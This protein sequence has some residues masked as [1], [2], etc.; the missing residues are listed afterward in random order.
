[1]NDPAVLYLW[2]ATSCI[3]LFCAV[4]TA[5]TFTCLLAGGGKGKVTRRKEEVADWV[6]PMRPWAGF[7]ARSTNSGGVGCRDLYLRLFLLFVAP[8]TQI[9]RAIATLTMN[10]ENF[11]AL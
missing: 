3:A 6:E 1:M 2:M 8:L 7:A 11:Y 9:V 10:E 4:L 5:A